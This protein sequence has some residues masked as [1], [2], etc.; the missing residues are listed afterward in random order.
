MG[1]HRIKKQGDRQQVGAAAG[2][3]AAGDEG[4]MYRRGSRAP[5]RL[6]DAAPREKAR[7]LLLGE[8]Q[9]GG[10]AAVSTRAASGSSG[11]SLRPSRS[12]GSPISIACG[13]PAAA[14][15]RAP[16]APNFSSAFVPWLCS[17]MG[18]RD[19]AC[20]QRCRT[21]AHNTSARQRRPGLAVPHETAPAA[22]QRRP[23]PK[24]APRCVLTP[25]VAASIACSASMP[26]SRNVAMLDPAAPATASH[27]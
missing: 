1:L 22:A 11:V 4:M 15:A 8:A 5:F 2:T 25:P 3:E 7:R 12:A 21:V 10:T 16:P 26:I 19:I 27:L 17:G 14:C 6:R 23:R 20:P 13:K 24:I 18:S 9:A